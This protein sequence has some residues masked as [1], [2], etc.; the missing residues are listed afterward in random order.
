MPTL[1]YQIECP[2]CS[3]TTIVFLEKIKRRDLLKLYKNL[4]GKDFSYLINQD[5]EY[6]FCKH[7]ELKFYFPL[8][9]G[10][11]QFYNTLQK[12]NWYYLNNKYEFDYAKKFIKKRDHV[13]EIGAGRGVFAKKLLTK[14][15]IGLDTS[16]KAKELA[17]KEGIKIENETIEDHAKK[18]NNFYDVVCCFQV[19]EHVSNP[20]NFLKASIDVLRKEG[21]LI[22][23]VPSEN[24]FLKFA[25]NNI[26]NMPPHHLTRWSDS[27]LKYL[28]KIFNLDII[29]IHHE[30][31]SEIHKKWYMS[32]LIQS[33][34]LK[35]KLLDLS[36]KRKVIS[37]FSSFLSIILIS[38][39]KKEFFSYGHTV[40]AVFRK[41]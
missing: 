19:L 38:R 23:A 3:S 40:I 8:I 7:C 21:I 15:Y 24:S 25:T 30:P 29:E 18:I 31:V 20:K 5:L 13:L 39:L 28:S 11:E 1:R 10:D 9:T 41:K 6:Y 4:T 12:F 32:T 36:I 2:L 26:L 22:I 34:L 16:Q 27:T 14:N 33:L 35:P 17:N 37:K